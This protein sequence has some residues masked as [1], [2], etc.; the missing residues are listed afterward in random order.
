MLTEFPALDSLTFFTLGWVKHTEAKLQKITS[1]NFFLLLWHKL[2]QTFLLFDLQFTLIDVSM[3]VHF[4]T[5]KTREQLG[6]Q[7]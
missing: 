4:H 7:A 3:T 5:V 1:D 2:Y 6:K